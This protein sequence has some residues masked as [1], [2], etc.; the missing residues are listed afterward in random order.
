MTSY[1]KYLLLSVGHFPWLWDSIQPSH[2]ADGRKTARKVTHHKSDPQPVRYGNL[3]MNFPA[4][5][6]LSRMSLR[7][8]MQLFYRVLNR[9]KPISQGDNLLF[10]TSFIDFLPFPVSLHFIM[11]LP[12]I[13]SHVNYLHSKPCS[14]SASGESQTKTVRFMF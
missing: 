7:Y 6:T 12:G 13:T 2:G 1:I 4:F 10:N 8:D 14:W 3:W 5:L 11:V 9:I